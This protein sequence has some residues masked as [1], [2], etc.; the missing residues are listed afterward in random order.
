MATDK[1]NFI[2]MK[3]LQNSTVEAVEELQ[4]KN[5]KLMEENI[6]LMEKLMNC[7]KALDINKEIMRNALTEQNFIKDSYSLEIKE[8]KD[9]I[10]ELKKCQ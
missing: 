3:K 6:L 5:Q 10:K 8:L 2:Y 9:Q 4:I 1:E 7:Q